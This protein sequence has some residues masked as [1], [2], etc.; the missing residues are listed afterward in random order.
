MYF[1]G[2]IDTYAVLRV[3]ALVKTPEALVPAERSK[4]QC[5]CERPIIASVKHTCIVLQSLYL[6]H[7]LTHK[8][9]RSTLRILASSVA[10]G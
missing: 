4:A 7:I 6:K 1:K 8:G 9:A 2:G 10:Y 5:M 3:A